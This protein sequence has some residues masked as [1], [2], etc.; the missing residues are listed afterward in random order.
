MRNKQ[1]NLKYKAMQH[2]MNDMNYLV[3][4]GFAEYINDPETGKDGWR[5]MPEGIKLLENYQKENQII[6]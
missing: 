4:L 1:I 6:Q 2:L 3:D 5:I